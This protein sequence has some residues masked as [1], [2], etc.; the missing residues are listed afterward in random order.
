[1]MFGM[2]GLD[3]GGNNANAAVPAFLP[4]PPTAGAGPGAGAATPGIGDGSGHG[5]SANTDATDSSFMGMPWQHARRKSYVALAAAWDPAYPGEEINWYTEY[6]ARETPNI[7]IKW[8]N[9]EYP[10]S[11]SV[12]QSAARAKIGTGDIEEND[13]KGFGLFPRMS[14]G[15]SNLIVSPLSDGTVCVWD[16][17]R[18]KSRESRKR[19]HP[20]GRSKPGIL[21]P[22]GGDDNSDYEFTDTGNF[23]SVDSR[24]QKAH[25][26]VGDTLSQI[27]LSTL[28]V[29][30]QQRFEKPIFALSQEDSGYSAPL[31]VVS[32]DKVCVYDSRIRFSGESSASSSAASVNSPGMRYDATTSYN[33]SI[34]SVL[35]PPRP[36]VH[37]IIAAGRFPFVVLYDRRN[38]SNIQ[39]VAYSGGNLSSLA[40]VPGQLDRSDRGDNRNNK[41]TIIACGEYRGRGS[42]ELFGLSASDE[43]ESASSSASSASTTE[44]THE[45]FVRNRQNTSAS[46]LLSCASHGSRIVFSDSCGNITWMERDGQAPSRRFGLVNYMLERRKARAHQRRQRLEAQQL[47]RQHQMRNYAGPSLPLRTNHHENVAGLPPDLPRLGSSPGLGTELIHDPAEPAIEDAREVEAEMS[48]RSD[49]ARKILPLPSPR[50]EGQEIDVLDDGLLIWTGEEVG[51]LQFGVKHH[52]SAEDEDEEDEHIEQET[53]HVEH[54]DKEEEEMQ[55]TDYERMMKRSWRNY[56]NELHLMRSFGMI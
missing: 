34:L 10:G 24:H 28:Q 49:I 20:L 16:L 21:F 6:I 7:S 56:T 18:L 12:T 40:A 19:P 44:M 8:L 3:G 25:V 53:D 29:V 54:G 46:K 11:N 4:P 13:I 35:H 38:L 37:S 47:Q 39:S 14:Y 9:P 23:V 5:S 55:R 22:N 33:T 45:A 15:S 31:S 52:D 27:D 1:M 41:H 30:A 48:H 2:T 50:G 51:L 26:A 43:Q 32:Y 42:L 36:N 17:E